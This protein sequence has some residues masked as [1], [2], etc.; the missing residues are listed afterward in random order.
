[1]GIVHISHQ[2]QHQVATEVATKVAMVPRQSKAALRK[3]K[4][5]RM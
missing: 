1:L 5:R 3:K 4:R 2:H